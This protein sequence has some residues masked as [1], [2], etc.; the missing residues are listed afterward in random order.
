M[1][2]RI[3]PRIDIAQNYQPYFQAYINA[4]NLKDGD[5]YMP[6][7]YLTWIQRKHNDFRKLHG[8]PADVGYTV[9]QSRMFADYVRGR[10]T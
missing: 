2:G 10:V 3:M 5:E 7:E 4:M 6:H 9:E 1:G 8:I